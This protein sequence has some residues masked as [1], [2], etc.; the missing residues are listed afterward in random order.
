[1]V[2]EK[3]SQIKPMDR[4]LPKNI[5]HKHEFIQTQNCTE[6]ARVGC[7]IGN[8]IG[9]YLVYEILHNKTFAIRKDNFQ[10]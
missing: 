7:K 1:M 3:Y 4:E 10:A 8:I 9:S 5:D 2:V 6:W